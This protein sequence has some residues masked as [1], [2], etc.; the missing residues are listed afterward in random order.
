MAYA[1]YSYYVSSFLGSSIKEEEFSCLALRASQFLDYYT[2][3]KSKSVP[4]LEN[5]KMACCAVAER[6]QVI[7]SAQKIAA[8]SLNETEDL[9]SESV[10]SYSV[11]YQTAGEK[12]TTAASAAEKARAEL[13]G[14]AR[15]YLAGTGLLYRG[16]GCACTLPTL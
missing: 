8:E 10:G 11:S 3:N 16:R 4:E 7:E 14:I 2:M 1:D 15:Q 13:V 5:L 6:Y 9:K 12:A